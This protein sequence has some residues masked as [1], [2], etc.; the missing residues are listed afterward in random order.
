MRDGRPSGIY[1]LQR[2][3]NV[4]DNFARE[5]LKFIDEEYHGLPFCS[6][7]IVRKFGSRGKLALKMIEQ[8]GILHQYAQLVEEGKGRVAQAEHT[9]LLFDGK[10]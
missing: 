9:V 6:R 4:R 3:G 2:D 8:S 7:W 5:V 1:K 10:K